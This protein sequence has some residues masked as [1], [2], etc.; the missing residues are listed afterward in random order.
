MVTMKGYYSTGPI[1]GFDS[2][3]QN[4]G[5]TLGA[6][7]WALRSSNVDVTDCESVTGGSD[8]AWTHLSL[9]QSQ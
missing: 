4:R 3:M 1:V 8:E 7:G 5:G 6:S 2:K 9:T